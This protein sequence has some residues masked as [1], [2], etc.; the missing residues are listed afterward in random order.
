MRYGADFTYLF[1][2][3]PRASAYNG[4]LT[5]RAPGGDVLH[6][7][8]G[9]GAGRSGIA[10]LRDDEVVGAAIDGDGAEGGWLARGLT[11]SMVFNAGAGCVAPSGSALLL[12]APQS[13]RFQLRR[14]DGWEGVQAYR[15]LLNGQ[16]LP[17]RLQIDAAHLLLPYSAEDE[18]GQTD[19]YILLPASRILPADLRDYLAVPLHA[20]AAELRYAAELAGQLAGEIGPPL[21]QAARALLAGAQQLATID[22]YAAAW[23]AADQPIETVLAALDRAAGAPGTAAPLIRQIVGLVIGETD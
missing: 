11:S 14:S 2:R 17:A 22:D 3:N 23:Q 13:G 8:I 12:T 18:H 19:L 16:L 4:M 7:H 15:L 6:L 21:G 1:V 20:R 9:I 10:A 5:Y